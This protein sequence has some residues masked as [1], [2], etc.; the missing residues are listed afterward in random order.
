MATVS[1]D[2]R[3]R[4]RLEGQVELEYLQNHINEWAKHHPDL[5]RGAMGAGINE[6]WWAVR[7]KMAQELRTRTGQLQASITREVTTGPN[8]EID[9]EVYARP[10]AGDLQ[11]V[12]L[13]ALERG[14]Y[15]Q[16]PGGV[17]YI[18]IG[19][20]T[21]FIRKQTAEEWERQGRHVA[22]TKG[23]YGIRIKARPMFKPTL[24]KYRIPIARGIL[25]EILEGFK[26][27]RATVGA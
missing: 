19:G 11:P 27:E 5:V 20:K 16:H 9:G 18:K 6:L 15:R 12:K 26:R 17:P 3:A 10:G 22:R 21:I 7:Q 25:N 24:A 2:V 14:S 23:P 1:A 4:M 13:R 8:G